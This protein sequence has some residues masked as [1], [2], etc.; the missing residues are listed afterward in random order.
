M[1]LN[2]LKTWIRSY[3][4]F[5]K[6][7]GRDFSG[8]KIISSAKKGLPELEKEL[9]PIY[10]HYFSAEIEKYKSMP[11]VQEELSDMPIWICWWQGVDNMPD[12]VVALN[13]ELSHET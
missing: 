10:T 3:V 8:Y 7:G 12:V 13:Q 11:F 4:V 1:K 2:E 9:M 5:R 6:M